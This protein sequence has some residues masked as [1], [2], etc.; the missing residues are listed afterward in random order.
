L[1]ATITHQNEK[2]T[3]QVFRRWATIPWGWT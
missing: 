1:H 3:C 2:P